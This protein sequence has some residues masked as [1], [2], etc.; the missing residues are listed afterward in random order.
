MLLGIL[1]LAC[2]V[3]QTHFEC[4]TS[5]T[6]GMNLTNPIVLFLGVFFL[7]WSEYDSSYLMR[8]YYICN[9]SIDKVK[10]ACH[11]CRDIY[12]S[13]I[14]AGLSMVSPIYLI[15]GFIYSCGYDIYL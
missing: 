13:G 15:S 1:F 5:L 4:S 11:T 14:P 7:E 3:L 2:A 8:R 6:F 10:C 12:H 9:Y